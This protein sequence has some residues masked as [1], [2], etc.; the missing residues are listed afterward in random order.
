MSE[1]QHT[2]GPWKWQFNQN[3]K[4]VELYSE[5]GHKT[6]VMDFQRWGM[7]GA[8]PRFEKGGLLY[9]AHE[10]AQVVPGRE[11]HKN[12][13]QSINHPDA[14]LIAAAPDL[15]AVLKRYELWE[16]HLIQEDSMWE[17]GVTPRFTDELY[18]ELME[19]QTLRNDAIAKAL[20]KEAGQL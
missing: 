4:Q 2:P 6:I 5:T 10:F 3:N 12:W 1:I 15:L 7:N 9:D 16:A 18:E 13:F 19:L 11:H 14:H 17:L 8:Q 20:G